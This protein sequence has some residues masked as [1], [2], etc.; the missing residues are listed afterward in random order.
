M[1]GPLSVIALGVGDTFSDHRTP[2]AFLLRCEGVSL[3]IDC[4]DGYRGALRRASERS[5][6]PLDLADVDHLLITH[7]H[8]DHM[9]GLEGVAF[10]RRF[11]EGRRVRLLTSPELRKSLWHKR[12]EVTMGTLW[13]GTQHRT[14]AFED[15]FDHT[16]LPWDRPL[17]VGPFTI[18]TRRTIHHVPTT[19]LLIEAG[20]RTLGYSA[21]TAF[22]PGLIDF[23][24]RADV[25]LHETNHGPAH[26][27]YPALLGVGEAVRE[28]MRLVHYPDD[29]DLAA[30]LIPVVHEG[31]IL[32]I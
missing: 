9:N 4:P 15:Y 16:P 32:Y 29:F 19:A 18:R 3:A 11:I 8:G 17:T 1:S 26:T 14:L 23:L 20:G 21:D 7:V 13:D 31:E 27:P 30:S 24:S 25:I 5:G 28:R 10:Y 22:D 12:L 6:I 2:T